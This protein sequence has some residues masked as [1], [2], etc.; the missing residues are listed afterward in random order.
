[1][2]VTVVW[3][4]HDETTPHVGAGRE[5]RSSVHSPIRRPRP[6]HAT[7]RVHHPSPSPPRPHSSARPPRGEITAS[8]S[9]CSDLRS[10][11]PLHSLDLASRPM[12]LST[13][14]YN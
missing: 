9:S 4:A 3:K 11:S 10:P 6:A 14:P 8:F 7:P 5:P 1:L 2:P 12:T 13:S